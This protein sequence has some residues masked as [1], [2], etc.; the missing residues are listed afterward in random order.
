VNFAI[1]TTYPGKLMFGFETPKG[2]FV[3]VVADNTNADGY[4]Y[5]NDGQWHQVSIPIS[6]FTAAGREFDLK[7][8]TSTFM[9]ADFY[10]ET[11]NTARGDKTKVFI[12]AVFWSK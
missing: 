9:I 10:A 3:R 11:G 7:A 5:V 8:V 1:K 12:D 4:G 2:G 6:A